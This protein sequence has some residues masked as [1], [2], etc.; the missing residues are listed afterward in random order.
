MIDKPRLRLVFLFGFVA[1]VLAGCESRTENAMLKMQEI[2]NQPPL[3]VEP[4]PTFTPVPSYSYSSFQLKSPFVPTSIANELKVM[5]GKRVYPNLSRPLQPLESY[6]LEELFMKG[7][8]RGASGKIIALVRTPDGEIEQ[9]QKGSY[10]GKN[11]G[12]I[13]GITP[14]EI[15]LIEVVPDGQ[16]GFIERPRN[17]VLY[18]NAQ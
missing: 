5:S 14:N 10:M 18:G 11:H 8:M 17:L 3:P 16:D 2:R 12:R 6:A 7:T 9:V 4:P 1:L 13:V 15:S